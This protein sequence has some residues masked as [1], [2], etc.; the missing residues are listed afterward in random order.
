MCIVP[1]NLKKYTESILLVFLGQQFRARR[2]IFMVQKLFLD[3]VKAIK[4][5]QGPALLHFLGIQ[6]TVPNAIEKTEACMHQG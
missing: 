6:K 4:I 3:S 2:R 5:C 1:N